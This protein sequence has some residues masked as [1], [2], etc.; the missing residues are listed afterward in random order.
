MSRIYAQAPEVVLESTLALAAGDTLSGSLFCAGYAKLEGVFWSN[1]SST[2]SGLR[3]SQS[4]DRGIHW[5]YETLYTISASVAS[6]FDV[7]IYGNAIK[8]A[9]SMG[10]TTASLQRAYFWLRPI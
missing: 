9:A 4:I 7:T 3:I 1:A 2:A 6:P 8:V 10:N 5:D